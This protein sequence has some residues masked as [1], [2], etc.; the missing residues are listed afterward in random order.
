[1]D[2]AHDVLNDAAHRTV[3]AQIVQWLERLRGSPDLAPV[4][5]VL[6]SEPVAASGELVAAA[7]R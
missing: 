2:N 3:A 1:M 7:S 5:R 6:S 4:I